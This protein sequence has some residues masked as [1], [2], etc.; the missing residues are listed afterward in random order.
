MLV[1]WMKTILI[2]AF[3]CILS[4]PVTAHAVSVSNTDTVDAVLQETPDDSTTAI[5]TES[6]ED[7]IVDEEDESDSDDSSD[8]GNENDSYDFTYQTDAVFAPVSIDDAIDKVK[9]KG[10]DLIRLNQTVAYYVI[11]GIMIIC[12]IALAGG[13]LGKNGTVFGLGVVGLILCIIGY[14][15]VAVGPYLLEWFKA[16][17]IS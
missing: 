5:A 9:D 12:A 13:K 14:I 10:G 4:Y 2:C 11:T 17:A 7:A 6:T 16:W 1:K 15:L 8:S 3:L